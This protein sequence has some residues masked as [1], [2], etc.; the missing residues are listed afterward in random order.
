MADQAASPAIMTNTNACLGANRLRSIIMP[1][2]YC[3]HNMKTEDVNKIDNFALELKA[4][5][6]IAPMEL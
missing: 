1:I 4:V 3:L 2:I 6:E 5:E